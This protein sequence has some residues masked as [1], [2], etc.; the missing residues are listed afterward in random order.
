MAGLAAVCAWMLFAPD[1]TGFAQIRVS[2]VEP[3][4]TD[5]KNIDK[6][7]FNTFIRSQIA[8]VRSRPIIQTALRKDE[9][10]RLQLETKHPDP[11]VYLEERLK[12]EYQ[13]GSEFITVSFSSPD[14]QEA[15]TLVKAVTESYMDYVNYTERHTRTARITELQKAFNDLSANLKTKKSNLSRLAEE[16]GTLD[17][18]LLQRQRDEIDANIRDLRT[19]RNLLVRELDR[20]VVNRNILDAQAKS[21]ATLPPPASPP[22]PPGPPPVTDAEVDQALERDPDANRFLQRKR[23]AE[24][25]VRDY[26]QNT[27]DPLREPVRIRAA[28]EVALMN[29]QLNR[30]R[31]DVRAELERKNKLLA[32]EMKK[33]QPQ[34]EPDRT[35][36]LKQAEYQATR[37]ALNNAI[38]TY[39]DRIEELNGSIADRSEDLKKLRIDSSKNETLKADIDRDQEVLDQLGAQVKDLEI[40][41]A[42]PDR[43]SVHVSGELLKKDARKQIMATA[44]GG[45]IVFGGIC[46]ALAYGDYRLRR[47]HSARELVRGVGLRLVGSVPRMSGLEQRLVD[48]EG[49]F[50]LQGHP[51]TESIDAIRTCLLHE[52]QAEDTRV[53]MVTSAGPGEGKTTLASH[54]AGSLARAGRKTLLLDGD[55]RRPAVHELFELPMQPGFSEVLL[56]EV[57]TPDA[58]QP[59]PQENLFVMTAGQWDREVLQALARD[60]LEG[61]FE[62]LRD[63]FEFIIVDSH[64]VLAATDA[65]LLGQRA[66]AVLLSVMRG[67]SQTPKV[68]AASLRLSALN[69]RVLGAVVNAADPEEVYSGEANSPMAVGV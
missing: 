58:V 55:L 52:A 1:F 34:A 36:E 18:D 46:F 22:A 47:V 19:Q 16:L 62:K 60:G 48:P 5:P 8:L 14:Q 35:R 61:V 9:V 24:A 40:N 28:Q 29:T 26:D 59:T 38:S 30:R 11:A 66:D 3:R 20:A 2:Y 33:R 64:P 17:D 42:A 49:E 4:L 37:L 15:V 27:V 65:L 43:I 50:D 31:G 45:V 63:E 67:I 39:Q 53:V 56:A 23:A 44:G 25:L 69:I 13:D 12:V 51:V 21:I 32:E 68:C 10:K 6:V 7:S 57:E 54:L 41:R